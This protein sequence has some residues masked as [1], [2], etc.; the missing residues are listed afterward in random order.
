MI[1]AMTIKIDKITRSKRKTIALMVNLKG[2][3]IIQA[4]IGASDKFIADLVQRRSDWIEAKKIEM[5]NRAKPE[6]TYLDGTVIKMFDHDYK[7]EAVPNFKYAMRHSNRIIYVSEELLPLTKYYLPQIIKVLAK[8]KFHNK[9][10][11][12]AK[13]MGLKF[14][15]VKISSAKGRWGSCSA[16]KNINLNWRLAL[17]PTFIVDYIIVHELAH[18]KEMNHSAKFWKIVEKFFPEHKKAR[19]W[20]RENGNMLEL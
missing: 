1:T 13:L 9:S 16:Q 2:Q 6:T 8:P 7:I 18:L 14:K 19:K 10:L 20:L 4:P 17:A 15:E 3:L 12:W 5:Q 11:D